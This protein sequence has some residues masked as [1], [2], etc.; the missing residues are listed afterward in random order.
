MDGTVIFSKDGILRFRSNSKESV[1][2]PLELI[3]EA[4]GKDPY[5]FFLQ[6]IRKTF[7][8]EEG[9]TIGSFMICLTPWANVVSD[10][11]DRKVQAYIDE[12]RK[13]SP[14]KPV[15]DRCEVRKQLSFSRELEY[16][17]APEGVNWLDWLNRERTPNWLNTYEMSRG[18]N[19]CGYTDGDPSNYSMSC[20]I[21]ELKNVPLVV[22]REPVMMSSIRNDHG[23]SLLNVGAAGVT[24]QHR[25]DSYNKTGTLVAKGSKDTEMTVAELIEVVIEQG[26]WFDTPAGAIN[27]TAM[28]KESMEN[29]N[30]EE[31]PEDEEEPEAEEVEEVDE[32]D[33]SEPKRMKI[34]VAPG[35]F[36]GIV[37]HVNR[38]A[39][40]WEELMAK[41]QPTSR[42]SYRI[43]EINEAVPVDDRAVGMIFK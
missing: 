20:S 10:L 8:L 31:E 4:Q 14:E 6:Q 21:H 23:P 38:E 26:L 15:F 30:L 22:N 29:L 17:P 28:L 7:I 32:E 1:A 13:P 2:V 39:E 19:I 9:S 42:L 5:P 25:E 36:S 43:G 40:E 18:Y 34:A 41:M 16:V 24:I 35:A 3:Q 33:D 12:I 37:N 27:M 11:T